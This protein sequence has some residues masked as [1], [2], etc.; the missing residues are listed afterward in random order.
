[1]ATYYVATDGD[2][3]NPGTLAEPF[4]T[5]QH[6]IDQAAAAGETVYVRGGTYTEDVSLSNSGI[7]NFLITLA[8]YSNER[9]ILDGEYTL[10]TGGASGTTCPCDPYD[11]F[12]WNPLVAITADYIVFEQ[13][14]IK[15]SRGFGVELIATD[16][17]ELNDLQVHDCRYSTI[18]S[19]NCSNLLIEHCD[20]W[21]SCDYCQCSRSSP[22]WWGAVIAIK[23][24]S[25]VTVRDS[26]AHESWSEGIN[27]FGTGDHITI[28]DNIVYNC[29]SIHIYI[30]R[31]TYVTVQRNL[32]YHTGDTFLK[33]GAGI[34]VCDEIAGDGSH[35][36][37][38]INNIVVG[39]LQN[40]AW[41]AWHE[42]N[43]LKNCIIAGNTFINADGTSDD[44]RGM[45]IG[46]GDH[47]AT[48]IKGNIVI[49]EADTLADV[50]D[51]AGLSFDYNDWYDGDTNTP[52]AA[53]QGAHDVN[54][55]PDLVDHNHALTAGAVQ[56]AWYKL[57]SPSPCRAAGI[58]VTEITEDYWKTTRSDPPDIGAHE[59]KP[60][61]GIIC[62][63]I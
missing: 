28:E 51:D 59:Y 29:Y 30:D 56:A 48:I 62:M 50:P 23:N 11:T 32:V 14:E 42:G 54:D 47:V 2:D 25:Y 43:G 34:A 49:Q 36:L 44:V 20:A 12:S 33:R 26:V 10:P 37:T 55:N 38:I 39:C 40:F 18:S 22:Y 41:W 1:M 61:G 5:I 3:A 24:G 46:T 15:R 16:H 27:T 31:S 53:A 13:F 63:V 57:T 58:A 6:G 4:L 8:G 45:S 19:E 17:N 21:G 9:P 7:A 60:A 35:H 52:V